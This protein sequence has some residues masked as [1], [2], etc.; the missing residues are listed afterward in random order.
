MG[1]VQYHN[2]CVCVCVHKQQTKSNALHV[3]SPLAAPRDSS[4]S[5]AKEQDVPSSTNIDTDGGVTTKITVE[6]PGEY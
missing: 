3:V 1:V 2:A 6:S 5:V 4:S